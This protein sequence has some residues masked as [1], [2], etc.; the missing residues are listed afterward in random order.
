MN[1]LTLAITTI[2]D[3]LLNNRIS[4]NKD[5]KPIDNINLKIPEYQR[6]YKWTARNAIQLLDDIIEAKNDN[7]E[8]YRVGTLI[9]H[10]S[11][12][13]NGNNVY[14]IVDGQQ[15]TI[16]FS[17]LLYALYENEAQTDKPTISFLKQKVFNN[18][19]SRHNIPNNLNAF[20]RRTQKNTDTDNGT[21]NNA[22]FKR[23][24]KRLRDF[25]EKQ[26]ELIVV[27]TDDL[28]EAFQFFDSQNARGKAL[29]PHDLLKAYHLRE[30]SDL[31]EDKTER[32]VMQWEK[33]P[34]QELASFFGDY[35]Y[36][37]KEWINGNW[38]YRL[39]EH[40]IYKFK[41][42]TKTA[43]TPYAQFYKSAFSYAEFINSS[44]M[45]FV[46]GTREANAFQL[47]TPI[48][49]GKPFFDYTRHYY[50][51]LKDIQDNSQYEGFYIKGNMIV[52][53]LDKYFNK[54]V[55]NRI[56]RLLFDTALLLY[57][58]RFC[59][60]TYPT[61]VDTELF[62]QF[63]TLAFI[64][65]YS[66]RAQYYHLGWQSAQNYIL[67]RCDK[68]IINSL[69]IYKFIADSDTPISL[70]ST[71]ADKLSPLS[72]DDIYDNV[73]KGIEEGTMDDKDTDKV[74]INYLHFFKANTFYNE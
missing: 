23:E 4:R 29:Y 13:A 3:L 15:R 26:C 34:Q 72:A 38:A 28:S 50:N 37:V 42:I 31:D 69:N 64:W 62:E 2:G 71:L 57:V 10:K 18:P 33:I 6:P 45:P 58:D 52:K 47:N 7:K 73:W 8:V 56:T 46:T 5:G 11:T 51:I 30:M 35:L 44:A 43:H 48:I 27:I 22:D 60:A 49:A 74:F 17:L 53:T 59:P 9:L 67:G 19:F 25:I 40:N 39:S 14:N 55:G 70:L 12:D 1:N 66:L 36:R 41:G 63:V 32:I 20:R 68:D 24:M 16:T 61:K 65:A 54:G 21:D